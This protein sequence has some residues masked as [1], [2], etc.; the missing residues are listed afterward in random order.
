MARE[1]AR[2]QVDIWSRD[3][4][5]LGPDAQRLYFLLCSQKTINNAG[6]LP[7]QVSKWARG[8]KKTTVDDI[9]EA[10]GELIAERYVFVDEHTEEALVRTFIRGDGI[11]KHK[12]ML[13]NALTV[14]R[15]TESPVLRHAL[16][17]ELRRLRLPDADAI[18][19]ELESTPVPTPPEPHSNGIPT[20]SEPDPNGTPSGTA[21][22]CH[23]NAHG[24]GEGVG[25]LVTPGSTNVDGSSRRPRSK[26]NTAR[27]GTRIPD[28]FAVTAEM[29]EW[30]RQHAPDVNG[31]RAT[32][33]FLDHFRS[34]P[35]QKGVKLDWVATWRNWLRTEQDRATRR[36]TR[37]GHAR[38]SST[39]RAVAQA[40]LLK[41]NPNPDILAAGGFT[42][43]PMEPNLLMLP[44][45]AA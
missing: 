4:T 27:R 33:A 7:L 34:A 10:L 3:F 22:E 18:A 5:E 28:D 9:R 24:E 38:Q 40:E 11:A 12:Y 13:K 42:P 21:S 41:S 31:R 36:S 37:S 2:I 45:G 15:Q 23:S 44:G 14:A 17:A 20:A 19:E 6:V 29:V 39:D 32:E 16:A 1:H 8:S 35:G 25:E 30:A 26:T 43:P